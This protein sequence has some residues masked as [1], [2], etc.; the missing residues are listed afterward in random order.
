M[1]PIRLASGAAAKKPS[2]AFLSTIAQSTS[3]RA[4][5]SK[6]QQ[7]TM[8]SSFRLPINNASASAS[9][10]ISNSSKT[11]WASHS[12]TLD[13]RQQVVASQKRF[14]STSP[15][16]SNHTNK[17]N[18][19]FTTLSTLAHFLTA[20]TGTFASTLLALYLAT[21]VET[22]AH[23]FLH[24]HFPH[25]YDEVPLEELPT[26]LKTHATARR[27]VTGSLVVADNTRAKGVGKVEEGNIDMDDFSSLMGMDGWMEQET[28]NTN[29]DLRI[30]DAEYIAA[31]EEATTASAWQRKTTEKRVDI[32]EQ[33]EQEFSRGF[34]LP[35]SSASAASAK[36]GLIETKKIQEEATRKLHERLMSVAMTA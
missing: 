26:C 4:I 6:H 7:A 2:A 1:M 29:E 25:W 8:K 5:L 3:S 18:N 17:N 30:M 24:E 20:G 23:E 36:N 27:K 32:I 35:Y 13:T 19:T 10:M 11:T 15:K 34:S 14:Q 16:N 31:D 12:T 22:S 28:L 9:R 33:E 21:V